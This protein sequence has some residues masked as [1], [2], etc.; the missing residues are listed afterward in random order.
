MK[1]GPPSAKLEAWLCY[2]ALGSLL[3][4]LETCS[5]YLALAAPSRASSCSVFIRA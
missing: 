1:V 5:C 4:T 2:L 3:V